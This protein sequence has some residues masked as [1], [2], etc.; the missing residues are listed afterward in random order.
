MGIIRV[1][2]YG[3]YKQFVLIVRRALRTRITLVNDTTVLREGLPKSI[4][5][6]NHESHSLTDVEQQYGG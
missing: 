6:E 2:N 3:R 1:G 5:K 4:Y